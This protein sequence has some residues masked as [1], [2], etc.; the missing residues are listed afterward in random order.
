MSERVVHR[1]TVTRAEGFQFDVAF[2][3]APAAPNLVMDEPAPLGAAAGPNAADLVCGAVANCLAASLLLCLQK[4]RAEVT[5]LS[6]T[7]TARI[8]RN[9]KG[10][11][12][13]VGIDVQI[14]PA[15]GP[16]DASKVDRC[17]GLFEDFCIVTASIRQGIPV[18]VQVAR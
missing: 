16:G 9:E 10:R 3:A 7:A 11:L 18:T 5:R 1:V 14:D 12:R 2:E 4:S 15:L 13:I 17:L 6:A 8:E